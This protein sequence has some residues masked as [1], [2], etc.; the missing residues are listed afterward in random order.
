MIHSPHDSAASYPPGIYLEPCNE[1][2]TTRFD[3]FP[4]LHEPDREDVARPAGGNRSIPD[5]MQ[6]NTAMHSY[7]LS[8]NHCEME[9]RTGLTHSAL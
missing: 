6:R 7:T 3:S 4:E 2:P 9:L 5:P 8:A 1:R